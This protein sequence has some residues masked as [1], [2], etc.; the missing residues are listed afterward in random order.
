VIYLDEDLPNHWKVFKAGIQFGPTGPALVLSLHVAAIGYARKYLTDGFVPLEFFSLNRL[1]PNAL[2]VAK[3]MASRRVRLFKVCRG[4]YR[5]HDFHDWNV[6]AS[7]IK[8]KRAS[9]RARK[10]KQRA[11]HKNVTPP[12]T[13]PVTAGH[14]EQVTGGVTP[15]VRVDSGGHQSLI[16]NHVQAVQAGGFAADTF[17]Q[18]CG[19]LG[20]GACQELEAL[21]QATKKQLLKMAFVVLDNEPEGEFADWRE[22]LKRMLARHGFTADPIAIAD[23]LEDALRAR[24]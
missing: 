21:D 12:V 8:D 11:R 3:V 20:G 6:S 1:M 23:A 7:E 17:P 18:G 19:N 13:P 10:Q 14:G 5:I 4:G 9:D 16:T 22:G 2:D 24:A 15:A